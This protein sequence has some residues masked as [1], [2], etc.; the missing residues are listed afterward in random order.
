MLT[1]TYFV[2]SDPMNSNSTYPLRVEF[3]KADAAGEEGQ[4]F[5]GSDSFTATDFVAGSKTIMFTPAA[6]LATGDKIV[7]TATDMRAAVTAGFIGPLGVISPIV[8][9]NTSEFSA[10]AFVTPSGCS[11]LVTTTADTISTVDGVNSL[12]EA[13]IC[14]NNTPG[15]DTINVPAG[16]YTLTIAGTG[17]NAAAMGDLDITDDLTL[18]G[19]GST[20][21]IVEAGTSSTNGIDRV[22]HILADTTASISGL[23]IR[24]GLTTGN[25]GAILNEGTMLTVTSST[26]T[27]NHADKGG[28]IYQTGG[29]MLKVDRS[30]ISLN[31][32]DK[33]GG[34]LNNSGT[35]EIVD[36]TISGNT[37]AQQGG[38]IINTG[39]SMSL[40]RTTVSGNMSG[41]AGGGG[42]FNRVPIT[43]INST[44]SGNK[45]AGSGGGINNSAAGTVSL[46]YVTITNNTADQEDNTVGD[47]GGVADFTDGFQ[48]NNTIIA[49]NFDK[50]DEAPDIFG[51]LDSQGFNLI[52]NTAGATITGTTTGNITGV[53]PLLGPLTDNGGFT[54][55]HALLSGSPAINAA[56]P[57]SFPATDQRGVTRPQGGRSDIGAFESTAPSTDLQITKTNSVNGATTL[58]N[59][60]T[61]TVHVDS[62]VGPATF[63]DGQTILLD[64]L[65]NAN[66]SY[67]SVTVANQTNIAGSGSISC[68]I[69]AFNDL[70]CVASGGPVTLGQASFSGNPFTLVANGPGTAQLFGLTSDAQGKV[71]IGNNS[72]NTTG[73]PLQVFDPALFTGTP[74]SLASFGPAVG[75]ADG[76]AFGNGFV[77]SGDRDEGLRR[78]AIPAGTSS[79][80]VAGTAING[81][82]SPVVVRPSDGHV[83]VGFGATIPGAP[84]DNRIDEYDSTGTFVQTFD[85]VGETET[86]TFDPISGLIYYA[87]F[88]SEVRSFNPITKVDSH[89]GNSS[90]TIDGGLAFDPITGLI[91]VGTANGTNSGR[92]ETIDPATGMT[93][94]FASGL[95]GSLGILREPV[96]GDLYFLDAN[97][98]YR[99]ASAQFSA[100]SFDVQFTATPSA[101]GL[102]SNPRSGTTS[103][104]Q[105][106]PNNAVLE[107]N[108]QNNTCS[109]G[110]LVTQ[111][112]AD[113]QITK[114][115]GVASAVPG[116]NLTYTIVV[117]NAGPNAAT[118]AHVTDMFPPALTGVTFTA[119]GSGNASGFSGGSG[120]IDQLVN[121]PASSTI[122]YTVHGHISSSATG[123]L[124]NTAMVSS[125]AGVTDANPNNNSAQDT[126]TLTPQ[127][128]VSVTKTDSPDKV[129]PGQNL[130]YTIVVTNQGPSDAQNV[131]LNES[132]PANTTFVSFAAPAGW[133]SMTPAPGGTGLITSNIS[134]LAAG[135]SATFTLIVQVNSDAPIGTQIFNTAS[136]TAN[137]SDTAQSNNSATATS[138]VRKAGLAECDISTL[139]EPGR[140]GSAVIVGD[141]DNPG[142]N[143]LLITG[144]SRGDV[145]V[146][147]PQ[148]KSLGIMRVV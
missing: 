68:S 81:T 125:P 137:T 80:F 131:T 127:A 50:G 140:P 41:T 110:V 16:T 54:F 59:N 115:D 51:T 58:G 72:N 2:P 56:N 112:T 123:T 13:I 18:V 70:T 130:T 36:S 76:L 101:T 86:M 135:A 118:G 102:F 119:T 73:I 48:A 69:G 64:N 60:W 10:S 21:T 126:D 87:D 83:F 27:A 29:G 26:L 124:S 141:A 144:T 12:R 85:T 139:N 84:G 52:G 9:N 25:G 35:V 95:D 4:I 47:G 82:G 67:D 94:P 92:V 34:I 43:I 109:N 62:S 147:E 11:L 111:V 93:K 100:G 138:S 113:L 31:V 143:V 107:S 136:V 53:N 14:A 96:T 97:H 49:G 142:S 114:T 3:F 78:T 8:P 65:P 88:D 1:V 37:S 98:L 32:V 66:I 19:A 129:L 145:I 61:W 91:F 148:P 133:T 74:I 105:V 22:F 122:T 132:T 71:Y 79:I 5:L 146:V 99:L 23:T 42:V 128:D 30:T 103:K 7:A 75:D 117:T 44:I 15:A 17:E 116:T 120:N 63:A 134:T 46:S 77:Y 40:T 38:G 104:C 55:T 90:G 121:L 33:G 45:T 24:N 39:T 28:G 108:E 106:D 57:A 20:T 6:S 89:V